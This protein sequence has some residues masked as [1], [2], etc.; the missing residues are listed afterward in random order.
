MLVGRDTDG[1]G[2][3]L[4]RATLRPWLWYLTQ[5]SDSKIFQNKSVPDVIREVLADLPLSCR[6]SA[7]RQLSHLG[8][9]RAIPGDGFRFVSRL[10]EHEGIYYWFRHDKGKHTLVHGR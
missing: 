2:Y 3:Y 8:I 9:L 1:G 6:I 5:T 7:G 4:Y 10:M